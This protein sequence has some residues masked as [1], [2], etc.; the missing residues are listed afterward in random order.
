MPAVTQDTFDQPHKRT[1]CQGDFLTEKLDAS[2]ALLIPHHQLHHQSKS[3]SRF[4]TCV[5]YPKIRKCSRI[6]EVNSST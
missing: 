1:S 6:A 2:R 4:Q 3:I 5:L